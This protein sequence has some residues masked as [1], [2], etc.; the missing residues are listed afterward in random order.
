[1]NRINL[2]LTLVLTAGSSVL[3]QDW[4]SISFP[5]PEPITGIIM[6]NADSGY[7]VTSDGN[8]VKT[9]DH[10]KTWFRSEEISGKRLESLCFLNPNTGWI[11]GDR[12]SILFTDDGGHVWSDQSW[13]DSLVIFF[14]IEMINRDTGIVVGMRPDNSNNLTAIALKTVDGGKNWKLMEPMGLAYSEAHFEPTSHKLYFMSMG[15]INISVDGARKW[16][17]ISTI[18]GTPAR[19]FSFFGNAG[20]MAG[21]KGVCAYSAD[22]GK[23]WYKNSRSVTQHFISSVMVDSHRGYIAGKD[24]VMLATLDGGRNWQDEFLPKTFVVME[25]FVN[26]TTIYAVGSDGTIL[27][28]NLKQ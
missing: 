18:E 25:M 8:F 10:G 17:S 20:I 4:Q 22:G 28:K 24:G 21:P 23:T 2:I 9:F 26:G 11:C 16:K 1:M 19:T 6:F 15:R 7:V 3:A 27:F 13:S 12:G 5:S 14:D